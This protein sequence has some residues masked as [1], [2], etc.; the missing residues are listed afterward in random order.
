MIIPRNKGSSDKDSPKSEMKRSRSDLLTVIL[1]QLST[2][3]GNTNATNWN[4]LS[5]EVAD[6]TVRL[7]SSLLFST[8][9]KILKNSISSQTHSKSSQV[10][11]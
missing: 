11:T 2:S 7:K 5:E 4:P 6:C 10:R 9:I 1:Q 8:Q 3:I